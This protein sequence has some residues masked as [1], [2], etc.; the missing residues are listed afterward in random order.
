[1]KLNPL[2]FIP[3]C[4][5]SQLFN[6]DQLY[7]DYVKPTNVNL[8]P[9]PELCQSLIDRIPNITYGGYGENRGTIF[10]NT[11]LS[12]TKKFIHLGVDINV[13]YGT[14]IRLP[15]DVT[16][17]NRFTD[18]DI[19]LGWGG[20]MIVEVKK[21]K[22]ALVFAH[23][24]YTLLPHK[25]YIKAGE[26]LGIVGTWPTNGNTFEHLHI[27]AIDHRNFHNFDGYGHAFELAYNPDPFSI[28]F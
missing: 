19:K 28:D 3:N 18:V 5:N 21:N 10:A 14:V 27:Q 24:D 11:Y 6:L 20:R 17:L 15:F 4:T 8:Y 23:L 26:M 12:Q 1:M 16:V 22:P 9:T 2:S 13:E 7:Q 25:T